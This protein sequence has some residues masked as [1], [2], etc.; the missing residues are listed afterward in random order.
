MSNEHAVSL[1]TTPPDRHGTR[2]RPKRHGWNQAGDYCQDPYHVLY[3]GGRS[4]SCENAGIASVRPQCQ[5]VTKMAVR[6]KKKREK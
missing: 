5:F 6:V 2:A 1:V 4:P 3:A